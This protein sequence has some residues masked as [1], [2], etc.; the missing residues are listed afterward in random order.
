[1]FRFFKYGSVKIISVVFLGIVLLVG[2][3]VVHS[4]QLRVDSARNSQISRLD[5]IG[6]TVVSEI[7]VHELK[8]AIDQVVD[9]ENGQSY[10][11]RRLI[12]TLNS[13]SQL[14]KL[15]NPIRIIRVTEDDSVEVIASSTL[16]SVR[17]APCHKDL[18]IESYFSGRKAQEHI[19]NEATIITSITQLRANDG[20]LLA[21]VQL[22]FPFQTVLDAEQSRL[23]DQVLLSILILSL[24]GI[25]MF[26]SIISALHKAAVRESKLNLKKTIVE[27]KN[28]E[29]TASIK[30]AQRLQSAFNPKKKVLQ[31]SFHKF[32]SINIPKDIIGGDF[33]WFHDQPSMNLKV[34]V[35]AD[36]TGHGV[37]GAMMGVLGNTLLAEIVGDYDVF[38]PAMILELMNR[39]L[40]NLLQQENAESLSDGM[41]IAVCV[42]NTE[43]NKL[44][45]AAANQSI[46]V[47]RDNEL[48]Q[49]RGDRNPI[50]GFHFELD[51]KFSNKKVDLKKNDKVYMYTDGYQD[52]FGGEYGK[53]LKRKGFHEIILATS[54]N[55]FDQQRKLFLE[56]FTNWKGARE[57]VDDVSLFGFEMGLFNKVCHL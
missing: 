31:Q 46:I 44:T 54:A 15:K 12:T 24:L 39:K 45:Y 17:Q 16:Q 36:C 8:K 28:H 50:G 18:L 10:S 55:A 47:V 2:T 26:K 1:M 21:G 53:R 51:R 4:Y 56:R 38:D 49:L 32:F 11:K 22:T 30:Y 13:I 27:G 3:L 37:P 5:V 41:D 6:Q 7:D 23:F 42:L 33:F 43:T 40:M 52:Q 25:L 57:Q 9:E 34:V 29:L 14:Y 20:K 19:Y 35:Q 48:V